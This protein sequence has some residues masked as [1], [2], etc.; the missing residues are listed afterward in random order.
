[1]LYVAV[2]VAVTPAP[3][4]ALTSW[5]DVDRATVALSAVKVP[6]RKETLSLRLMV[7]VEP[8]IDSVAV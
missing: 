4:S 7:S 1:L 6:V 2:T 3:W 5:V 8:G